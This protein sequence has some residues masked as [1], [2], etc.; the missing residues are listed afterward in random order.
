MRSC[1]QL[2]KNTIP[3]EPLWLKFSVIQLLI[4]IRTGLCFVVA[5]SIRCFWYG[6]SLNTFEPISAHRF[7]LCGSALAWFRS[8]LND[9]SHFVCI[10]SVRSAIRFPYRAV[11]LRDLCWDRYC[12][13]LCLAT[14]GYC[15]AVQHGFSILC[16]WY[17]VVSLFQFPE[18][19][20]SG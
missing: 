10:R 1:S 19:R 14:R 17:S 11:C 4:L 8:Y 15:K 20:W 6:R 18:C 9:R 7:G 12:T 2:T 5:G 3:L 13:Y 16:W